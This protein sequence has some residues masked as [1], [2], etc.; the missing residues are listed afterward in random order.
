M[1][2]GGGGGGGRFVC[3]SKYVR[4]YFR[5]GRAKKNFKSALAEAS[6]EST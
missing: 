1:V 2:C 6:P 3:E 5:T 4:E